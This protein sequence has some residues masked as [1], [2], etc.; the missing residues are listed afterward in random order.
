MSGLFDPTMQVLSK[1]LDLY[2]TRHAV[3][4]DNIANAETPYFKARRVDFES[5][6]QKAIATR[7][8]A[9]GG[10]MLH[11]L[12]VVGPVVSEEPFSEIGQDLNTVDMDREMAAMTK[13]DIKYS[14]ATQAISKKF[15][16]L[17]FSITE[18]GGR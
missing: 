4:S 18:G 6:L 14:A 17:K 7:D 15:A 16:L 9:G 11:E 13:N 10:H 5:N 8:T 2:L 3:I 1:S 12:S